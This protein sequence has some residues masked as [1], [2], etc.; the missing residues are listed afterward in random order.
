MITPASIRRPSLAC[1]PYRE[2]IATIT[3]ERDPRHLQAIEEIM[4]I[5]NPTLDHL[6]T[7]AFALEARTAN[8]VY[9]A[10]TPDLA[11]W[12]RGEVVP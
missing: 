8:R 1:S 3:G 2:R 4:R 10:M 7:S 6:S 9:K 11:A 5:D 12:Y